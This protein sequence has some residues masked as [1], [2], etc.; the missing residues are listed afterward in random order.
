MLASSRALRS[1]RIPGFEW[2]VAAAACALL[3]A[4]TPLALSAEPAAGAERADLERQLRE[5]RERLDDAAT[6]VAELTRRLYGEHENDFVRFMSRPPRGAMLGINIG[7]EKPNPDGVLVDGVSP[8]GP[9]A[10][11]GLRSGDVITAL[12][13][14]SLSAGSQRDPSAQLV[15]R[16]RVTEPG[17]TVQV[18]YLRGGK[19]ETTAVT[20]TRAEP[21]V[22]R[23]LR[24]VEALPM[25]EGVAPL[26][27]HFA[28]QPFDVLLDH[29]G[30]RSL[31]LV[32]VT[33]KL[34]Q[35]FGTDKGM[36]VVRAPVSGDYRLEEGDVL[37]S[38]DGRVPESP[39]HAFRILRS[40][41]PGE[42][43][44]LQ[45]LR[46][47]KR[48]DLAARIPTGVTPPGAAMRA[49]LPPPP[50]PRPPA[51]PIRETT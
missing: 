26:L 24:D 9:A 25:V 31:E 29:G 17:Q 22:V 48:I 5:A 7:T 34:G 11:A 15:E 41:E 12:N 14:K 37:L 36:L 16:L 51:P 20:T 38:I 43:V 8:G 19:R 42:Q 32:P 44:K 39:G 45:V 2:L 6:D 23:M 46:S 30:F 28:G 3:A 35:Y 4:H 13:G 27:G 1:A 10:A 49:P 18:E 33:P 40:Y 50:P 47:R 21:A